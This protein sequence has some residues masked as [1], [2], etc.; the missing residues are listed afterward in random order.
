M[1]TTAIIHH[2]T[3]INV[4]FAT[5]D[6]TGET[7]YIS[8]T[9]ATRGNIRH[10]SIGER[11]SVRVVPNHNPQ[12]ANTT[13]WTA[14]LASPMTAEPEPTAPISPE[15]PAPVAEVVDPL[16][17]EEI[18]E[19]MHER[20]A[21]LHRAQDIVDELRPGAHLGWSTAELPYTNRVHKLLRSMHERGL[22][23]RADLFTSAGQRRA[24]SRMV[25]QRLAFDHAVVI[26]AAAAAR[27]C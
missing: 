16:T 20:S 9:V 4:A 5:L 26:G 15:S 27:R 13:P 1:D 8:P 21:E 7:C 2:V 23:A 12:Y 11:I 24:G 3:D 10:D 19:F 17:E 6:D 14:V 25:P 18:M 22:L